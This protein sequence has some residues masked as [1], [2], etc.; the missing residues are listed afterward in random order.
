MH[1]RSKHEVIFPRAMAT[2]EN[3]SEEKSISE[4][5]SEKAK[6]RHLTPIEAKRQQANVHNLCVTE[7]DTLASSPKSNKKKPI[8]KIN[9]KRFIPPIVKIDV[10]DYE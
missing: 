9:N 4:S 2:L 8:S 5:P 3:E 1:G 7:I 6:F 10:P